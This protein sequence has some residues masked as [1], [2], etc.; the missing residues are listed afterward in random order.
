MP[1]RFGRDSAHRSCP[2]SDHVKGPGFARGLFFVPGRLP[3]ASDLQLSSLASSVMRTA[4]VVQ[5]F[6][7]SKGFG[8]ISPD[9]GN[10]DCVVHS[11]AIQCNVIKSQAEGHRLQ[12]D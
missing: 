11:S 7:D 5:W 6:N 4:G 1:L 12:L 9:G 8:V 10:K 3:P 2:T